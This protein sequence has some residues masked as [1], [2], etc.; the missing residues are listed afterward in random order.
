MWLR[1]HPARRRCAMSHF[2]RTSRLLLAVAGLC[3]FGTVG[4]VTASGSVGAVGT[5]T[6]TPNSGLTN[7]ETVTVSA[8]GL[9]DSAFGALVECSTVPNQPT[10]SVGGRSDPV[11]CTNTSA[12]VATT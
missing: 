12:S 1:T 8:T 11:S 9:A 6:V 7:G 10:I 4:L 3:A 2:G 5:L